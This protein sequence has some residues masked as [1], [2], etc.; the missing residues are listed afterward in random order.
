MCCVCRCEKKNSREN[1]PMLILLHCRYYLAKLTSDPTLSLAI[2]LWP[3]ATR[4]TP[5]G[6][7]VDLT[8]ANTS[9]TDSVQMVVMNIGPNYVLSHQVVC[10]GHRHRV[11]LNRMIVDGVTYHSMDEVACVVQMMKSLESRPNR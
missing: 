8:N 7:Y 10:V 11:N 5:K 2:V 1:Y 4:L 9:Y 6:Q 3:Y